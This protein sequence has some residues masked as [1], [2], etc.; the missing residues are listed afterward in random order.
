MPA[1]Q[2]ATAPT[3]A[4]RPPS[5]GRVL[6]ALIADLACVVVF[7]AIGRATHDEAGSFGGTISTVWPFVVGCLLGWVFSRGWRAPLAMM[8]RGV[9]VWLSTVVV[10][11]LLRRLTDAGTAVSFVAVAGIVLLLFIVGWRLLVAARARVLRP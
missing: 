5:V 8:P 3:T 10:A 7:A 9:A 11:M 2:P 4:Q 1:S 6:V